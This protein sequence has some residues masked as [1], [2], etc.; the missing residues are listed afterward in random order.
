[1]CNRLGQLYIV[2]SDFAKVSNFEYLGKIET[3]QDGD[4]L[5][6]KEVHNLV[7]RTL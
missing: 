1:M 3:M 4:D 2:K 6:K 7:T 5:R